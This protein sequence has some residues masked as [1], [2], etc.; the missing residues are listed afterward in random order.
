MEVADRPKGI[1]N[2]WAPIK[3]NRPQ[4]LGIA[5]P[6]QIPKPYIKIVGFAF[7]T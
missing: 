3:S 6:I 7:L 1:P 4:L 2:E 5:P